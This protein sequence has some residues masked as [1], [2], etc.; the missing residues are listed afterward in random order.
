M[1]VTHLRFPR[2]GASCARNRGF[3][4]S[5]GDILF[6]PDD[7]C[8][9]PPE[10][11][12]RAVSSFDRRPDLSGLI[13]TLFDKE[14]GAHS[15]WV[16]HRNKRATLFDA[17]ILGAEP[18]IIL[19]RPVFELLGG[20]DEQI[21]TGAQSPWGA[22]EGTDLCVR[23]INKGAH[24]EVNPTLVIY[25]AAPVIISNDPQ[26]RQ[27]G[28]Y[29]ARGMGAVL[30]KNHLN[31]AFSIRYLLTYIRALL[32]NSIRLQRAEARFHWNR[33]SGLIEGWYAY[34]DA[35]RLYFR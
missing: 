10:L 18:A 15:R 35:Q 7:D 17:F 33:L 11:L 13:G 14:G 25:H 8:W 21:G 19:R 32:W 5:R 24:F 3:V 23:A 26:Q 31:T 22:G 29:Y 30:K 4:Y 34:P 27:K 28:K 9:Y 12:E 20:F 2:S 16:P 6:W 1:P